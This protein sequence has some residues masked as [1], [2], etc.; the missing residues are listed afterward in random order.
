MTFSDFIQH[1]SHLLR[2]SHAQRSQRLH[3]LCG[4][5]ASTMRETMHAFLKL[6]L[7]K[8]EILP[9]LGAWP[10]ADSVQS[11]TDHLM[12]A[13]ASSGGDSGGG[14]GRGSDGGLV[15]ADELESWLTASPTV[16]HIFD[17]TFV[18]CF[19]CEVLSPGQ[20]PAEL[21]PQLGLPS[22]EE[23]EEGE[24]RLVTDR[25]LVPLKT[26][27]P[28]CPGDFSSVLLSRASLLVINGH[29]PVEV[30]GQLYPLFSS[31]HHGESFS[32]MCKALVGR[33][34][35]LLV[36]RDRQG[37]VFGGFAADSWQFGPQFIGTPPSLLPF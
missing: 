20:I 2:G 26:Q 23:G 37:H 29:L 32:T 36:A 5:C 18:L 24:G 3:L 10:S 11:V 22:E 21:L 14:S 27:H 8:E 4:G 17:V 13:L 19:C 9:H 34:P 28:L 6:I 16:S 25:A 33:G 15:S 7:S 30:R 1:G 35:T 12:K 31:V